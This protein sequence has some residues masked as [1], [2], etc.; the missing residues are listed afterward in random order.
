MMDKIQNK[1]YKQ[2][3]EPFLKNIDNNILKTE[4]FYQE[5]WFWKTLWKFVCFKHS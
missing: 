5:K 2:D 1:F 3:D 4:A